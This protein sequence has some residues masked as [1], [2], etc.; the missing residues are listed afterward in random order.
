ML[1]LSR[2]E[3]QEEQVSELERIFGE[4]EITQVSKTV[5]GTPEVL[6]LMQ[7]HGAE[8]LVAVLPIGLI[9][10]LTEKGVH[11]IRA[12]MKRELNEK[13]EAIFSHDHFERIMQ[14]G[15]ISHPLE[16]EAKLWECK[17]I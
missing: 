16:E 5:S 1:W 8:E 6:N 12:V 2:H 17:K 9:A 7:E 11:P 14:I 10:E 4:V 15:I 3:P 13:G